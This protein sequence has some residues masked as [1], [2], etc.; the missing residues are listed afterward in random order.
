MIGKNLDLF[1]DWNREGSLWVSSMKV[2]LTCHKPTQPRMPPISIGGGI[3][4]QR[5]EN[6]HMLVTLN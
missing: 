1:P 4:E 5:G 6:K 2:S 3:G